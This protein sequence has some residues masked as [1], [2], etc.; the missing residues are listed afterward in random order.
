[1]NEN[2]KTQRRKDAKDEKFLLS[3]I[4]IRV[5]RPLILNKSD[6][7]GFCGFQSL[8]LCD[9]APLRLLRYNAKGGV[10]LWLRIQLTLIQ[11]SSICGGAKYKSRMQRREGREGCSA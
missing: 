7:D 3:V 1:M 6:S 8:R 9:F 11:K 5:L 2:A 4:Y 10:K